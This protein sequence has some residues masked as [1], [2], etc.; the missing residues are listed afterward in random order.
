MTHNKQTKQF[1][2]HKAKT[3]EDVRDFIQ[4]CQDAGC[5]QQVAYSTYHDA[6][7]Q[8]C[9]TC[10]VVVTNLDIERTET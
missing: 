9:F 8:V 1:S 6:L 2:I 5:V 3:I 7:T 10:G 4:E